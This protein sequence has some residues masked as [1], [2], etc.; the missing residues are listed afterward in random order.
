MKKKAFFL[1]LVLFGTGIS[2][3]S[4][5]KVASIFADNMVLQRNV[6]IPIW[7]VAAAHEKITVRFHNQIQSTEADAA[8]KWSLHL[9]KEKAGGPYQLKIIGSKSIQINNVLVGEVWL[10]GGQSNMEWSVGQSDNATNEIA[11]AKYSKIRQIKIP[12]EINSVPNSESTS[13]AWSVCSPTTVSNFTAVGYFFAKKLYE[14]LQVPIGLINTSWGGTN[15]ETWISREAF[16]NSTEYKEMITQMPV[17]D[18]KALL[19]LKMYREEKRVETIQN[20]VINPDLAPSFKNWEYDDRNWP[21]MTQ[22]K[23]WEEQSLGNFDGVV[24]LR[25]SFDLE[26]TDKDIQLELPAIDD[27]DSTFV[28]GTLVGNTIGWDIKRNYTIPAKLLRQG[29]NTIAIRV[30][31]NGGGGGIYGEESDL[32]LSSGEKSLPLHGDWKFQIERIKNQISENDFPSLCYNAMIRPLVP[33]AFKGVLWYQGESNAGRA[34]QYQK[35]FPLLINDWRNQFHQGDFPFYF[36]QLASF[37]TEGNS[38]KGCAWAELR[39][40]QNFALRIKNTGMVVTTDIGNP[41]SIHPTNKQTVGNRL[42]SIANS[43][44]YG[45]KE[46]CEGPSFKSY[47]IEGNKIR[48]F[49][50]NTGSGLKMADANGVIKGFEMAGEGQVF[51]AVPGAVEGNTIVLPINA[52]QPPVALRFGWIGDTSELNLF[53]KEGF[54][55]VPFR[56]DTWKTKTEVAK[57]QIQTN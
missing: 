14:K 34:F 12:K 29:K 25:K 4:Q 2:A 43:N 57:Y 7:G 45:H 8:G 39:E 31:D 5:V 30:V 21:T 41:A 27:N 33:F 44:L 10:C 20:A 54:P 56:T 23:I 6:K 40:A 1:L 37:K 3:S 9:N 35:A 18:F 49:F 16:E 32:R 15:I 50:N 47:R 17:I 13:G 11:S 36:V 26:Q 22:P 52:E 38:N 51:E 53:N 19:H 42:A 28:N 24:W 48:L 55:A 46:I